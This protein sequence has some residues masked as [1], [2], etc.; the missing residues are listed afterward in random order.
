[1]FEPVF[2]DRAV[3]V[4]G[5]FLLAQPDG[6]HLHEAAADRALEVRVWLHPVDHHDVVGAEGVSVEIDRKPVRGLAE[7]RRLDVGA[8]GTSRRRLVDAVVLQYPALA[9][10]RR[11]AVA[12]HGRHDEGFQAGLCQGGDHA[13]HDGR[14]VADPPASSG[15][16]HRGPGTQARLLDHAGDLP[17]GRSG[18]I[19][20]EGRVE[21]LAYL[22]EC[23]QFHVRSSL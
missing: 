19:L 7:T 18:D 22:P 2:E 16:G 11:S 10:R 5:A 1:M 4:A 15:D 9:F 8:D 23:G 6:Q 21:P 20:N 14:D 3:I 12:A 17:F 13:L